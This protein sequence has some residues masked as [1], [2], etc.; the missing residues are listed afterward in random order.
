MTTPQ[1]LQLIDDTLLEQQIKSIVG[2]YNTWDA[3]RR[4]LIDA[5]STATSTTHPTPAADAL[6]RSRQRVLRDMPPATGS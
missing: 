6:P 1:L 2:S 4:R 3:R 5:H